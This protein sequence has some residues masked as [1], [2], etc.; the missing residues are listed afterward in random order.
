MEQHL[1]PLFKCQVALPTRYEFAMSFAGKMELTR[2]EISL[3][4][5]LIELSFLDYNLNYFLASRVA[6]GA[7]HLA[8]QVC[9][10]Y[11]LTW[12]HY[13]LFSSNDL[14]YNGNS[15]NL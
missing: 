10:K 7:I 11:K 1:L 8:L 9:L 4:L 12:V 13:D 14:S 6:A 2:R 15:T 3:V 5:F